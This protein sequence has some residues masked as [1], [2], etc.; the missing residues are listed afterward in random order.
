MP[1]WH[2]K[3]YQSLLIARRFHILEL[4]SVYYFLIYNKMRGGTDES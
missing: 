4:A 1:E 3:K 2:E